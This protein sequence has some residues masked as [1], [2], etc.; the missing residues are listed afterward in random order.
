ME[1]SGELTGVGIGVPALL[2]ATGNEGHYLP[3]H[4]ISQEFCTVLLPCGLIWSGIQLAHVL[5][6]HL[7]VIVLPVAG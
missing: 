7:V 1:Y 2:R 3:L 5:H 6:V 4:E